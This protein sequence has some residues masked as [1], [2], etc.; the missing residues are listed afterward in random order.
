[1]Y[2]VSAVN[3]ELKENKLNKNYSL[4]NIIYQKLIQIIVEALNNTESTQLKIENFLFDQSKVILEENMQIAVSKNKD[5][6]YT[7]LGTFPNVYKVLMDKIPMI[8]SFL[9][10]ILN[11]NLIL[12][13]ELYKDKNK[14]ALPPKE[15]NTLTLKRSNLIKNKLY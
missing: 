2:V 9:D 3:R 8:E 1:V 14:N 15:K 6:N 10:G 5:I 4:D 11:K 7:K 12:V 13:K